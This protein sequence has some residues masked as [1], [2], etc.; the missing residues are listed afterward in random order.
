MNHS[1]PRDLSKR[2]FT[3][4]QGRAA[5]LS[6]GTLRGPRFQQPYY[7][8]RTAT[9]PAD[10]KATYSAERARAAAAL[11]TPRLRPGE[12]F[13]H[14]TALALFGCPIWCDPRPHLTSV[15]PQIRTRVR[16]VHGH[17]TSEAI[18]PWSL[19]DGTPLAPPALA[20]IQA[21][22]VLPFRELVVAADHLI[23][24]STLHRSDPPV[25]DLEELRAAVSQSSSRAVGRART[26]LQFARVGAESRMESILRLI[27][28]RYGLDVFELQVNVT[29]Q[30]GRWIGRFDLVNLARRI[31]LEYDG[32]QHRVDEE[33]YDRDEIRLEQARD[34]GFRVLRFR[35]RQVLDDPHGT[36]QRVA[37]ALNL[38]LTPVKGRLARYFAE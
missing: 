28:A 38:P 34:A 37:A 3:V 33:Q 30:D 36:A 27:L 23:R 22:S 19:P 20:F 13:S 7:G 5:G 11:F 31:I 29:D 17:Q 32:D 10:S 24:P 4:A 9:P 6:L 1:L 26:A 21:A 14:S 35:H 12:F 16:G 25:I 15:L 18:R 8:V 2:P